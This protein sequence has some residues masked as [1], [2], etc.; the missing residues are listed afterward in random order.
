M[1]FAI[2]ALRVLQETVSRFENHGLAGT[3]VLR[4][5]GPRVVFLQCKL[6]QLLGFETSEIGTLWTPFCTAPSEKP[7]KNSSQFWLIVVV[8]VRVQNRPQS[9]SGTP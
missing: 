2:L 4:D 7:G 6:P 5:G 3:S 8:L 9:D 1:Q